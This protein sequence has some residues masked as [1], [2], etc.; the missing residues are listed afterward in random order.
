MR[1]KMS[2]VGND[3]YR[4]VFSIP[5][6][7]K[8][9]FFELISV[10]FSDFTA[11]SD[12]DNIYNTYDDVDDENKHRHRLG[13]G[14]SSDSTD[15]QGEMD[16][17]RAASGSVDENDLPIIDIKK[18]KSRAFMTCFLTCLRRARKTWARV[19]SCSLTSVPLDDVLWVT[20]LIPYLLF[21]LLAWTSN[22]SYSTDQSS[23]SSQRAPLVLLCVSILNELALTTLV[24]DTSIIFLNV[25]ISRY[26]LVLCGAHFWLL[27][28][29]AVLLAT[30]AQQCTQIV[31][32][33]LP[34]PGSM[35]GA[36]YDAMADLEEKEVKMRRQSMLARL[37]FEESVR[38]EK[39]PI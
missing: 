18:K 13:S 24:S 17:R 6:L 14:H 33:Y 25:I 32:L 3:G 38:A 10:L 35:V 27:G 30:S 1:Q 5:T 15:D 34:S 37:Q 9:H 7:E 11:V 16:L 23:V 12:T 28:A 39:L 31:N 26:L 22:S 4:G 20:S 29:V 19:T 36:I 21:A 8:R 2:L